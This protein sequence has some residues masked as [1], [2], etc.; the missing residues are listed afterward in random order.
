[1]VPCKKLCTNV[2]E[3]DIVCRFSTTTTITR[4]V[5]ICKNR[6]LNHRFA[7]DHVH[8]CSNLTT[9]TLCCCC[10]LIVPAGCRAVMFRAID[11]LQHPGAKFVIEPPRRVWSPKA[12]RS[13]HMPSRFCDAARTLLLVEMRGRDRS[14]ESLLWLPVECWLHI[15]S[16]IDRRW[17]YQPYPAPLPPL[18]AR[19][20]RL[21]IDIVQ[22]PAAI[23]RQLFPALSNDA[24]ECVF[25]G[26][27]WPMSHDCW[28]FCPYGSS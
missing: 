18:L 9:C 2:A 26:I 28:L 24:F 13:M 10:Y 8:I 11:R 14:D 4:F 6:L 15:M 5:Q 22:L 1:M 3:R 20:S 7:Q 25:L 16:F 21:W 17:F 23:L 12:H 27:L 19:T